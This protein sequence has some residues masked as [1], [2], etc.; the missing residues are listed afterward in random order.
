MFL[1]VLLLYAASFLLHCGL[2]FLTI[3]GPKVIIDEG[4][5]TNIA[6]SLAWD[7]ELAFRGQPINYPFL[8]YPIF[9]V[10]VYW[11]NFWLKGDIYRYVQVFNTLLISSSVIPTF[12]FA[13]DFSKDEKK[14]FL[15][16]VLVAL[17]PDMVM[18][19]YEMT[20]CLLWPLALWLFFFGYRYFTEN[21]Y[22]DGCMTALTT[23]LMFF[24]KPGAIVMGTVLLLA[25]LI[26]SLRE[27][28]RSIKPSIV[29]IA[30]LLL[31]I[32]AVYGL[33][34]ALFRYP[35]SFIGLYSKQTSRWKP[36]DILVAIEAAILL[37]FLFIFTCG[38]IFGILPAAFIK[39]YPDNQRRFIIA[40]SIGVIT[41]IIGV[42]VFVVP[43]QW[44]GTLGKLPL[45]MR[46]C[47][48]FIPAY[49][50]FS[51]AI[52]V[53]DK[54][55]RRGLLPS[56]AAFLVLSLFPGARVGFVDGASSQVDSFALS[57]FTTTSRLNG[58]AMGW[59][60]TLLLIV[61]ILYL[62][63]NIHLGWKK[64]MKRV[65]TV[66]FALFLL[67][68]AACAYINSG[69]YIDPTIAI[70]AQEVNET[71]GHHESLGV[72]QRYYDDI[73]SYWLEGHLNGPMQQVTIDQMFVTMQ[74]TN[75]VYVPFVPQ[76][77]AP[78]VNNH[79]T[80]DTDTLVLGM[81]I[82][83]HLELSDTVKS[84]KT[85]NGHFTIVTLQ[86]G[87]RWVDSMF[88]GLD[89][90]TLHAGTEGYLQVFDM[91]RNREGAFILHFTASGKGSLN[92]Q[93]Q[94][95]K[96]SEEKK[97]YSMTVAFEPLVSILA[98]DEDARIFSY[99]TEK[100]R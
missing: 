54:K 80:P 77:Q 37:I 22:F 94:R 20:E 75:G 27:K 30:L 11:M 28:E 99:T 5:Y 60:V 83:E 68:N 70:D 9:L 56:L 89:N 35:T 93:G 61:F 98:E 43:Y 45:H 100:G 12:L 95:V 66:C 32:G 2:N 16:A 25:C 13:R 78:N 42:A 19:G 31:L 36:Q 87:Q 90:N 65:S 50:V 6:R 55:A 79:I 63:L 1:F 3:N 7:G 97:N 59:S 71:I 49:Y 24:S 41:V 44:N 52:D 4:L 67:A 58:T 47:S 76:E 84:V 34:L 26:R 96:L 8:L 38:G 17:M 64:K 88:Y 48:M 69:V 85:S 51:M 81:T 53:P 62:M 73:H 15:A 46:Y 39:H 92:I 21:R 82:A 86:P 72:T 57:S 29:S 23:G 33:Y 40:S 14:A 74:D 18:G 10:P 91:E